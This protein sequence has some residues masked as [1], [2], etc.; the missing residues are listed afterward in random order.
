MNEREKA[1][2]FALCSIDGL[3]RA[4]IMRLLEKQKDVSEALTSFKNRRCGKY[5]AK[6]GQKK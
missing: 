2:Y 4:G 3:G 1:E 6:R 5:W